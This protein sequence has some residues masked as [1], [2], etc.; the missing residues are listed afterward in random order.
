MPTIQ[1]FEDLKAWQKARLICQEVFKITNSKEFQDDY[2]FKH[3]IRSSCGSIMD[4]IA[5]GFE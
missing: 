3:Q 5:E 1:K 4:N 2:R